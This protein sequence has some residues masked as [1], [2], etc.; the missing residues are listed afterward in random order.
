[1]TSFGSRDPKRTEDFSDFGCLRFFC[2]SSLRPSF[3]VNACLPLGFFTYSLS[4]SLDVKCFGAC[5]ASSSRSSPRRGHSQMKFEV[6]SYISFLQSFSPLIFYRQHDKRLSAGHETG[7][8][9]R[10]PCGFIGSDNKTGR[11]GRHRRRSFSHR[12]E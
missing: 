7:L 4:C 5:S 8:G 12:P 9:P 1:M 11:G 2:C 3:P 10:L 6:I